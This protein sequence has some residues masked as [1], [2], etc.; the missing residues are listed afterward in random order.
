MS[1]ELTQKFEKVIVHLQSVLSELRTGR[2]SPA[3]VE[4]MP[5]ESYGSEMPLKS[6][7]SISIPEAR[8][9][10]IKPWDKNGLLAIQKA[11]QTSNIGLN[12]VV[13]QDSIR[14]TIPALTEER[15]KDLV[16]TMK[17]RLEEARIAIRKA[18]EDEM[19][20]IEQKEKGGE[21]SESEK[22]R[23]K[24]VAQK[25]VDDFN[26]K[27]DTMGQEKEKEIMTV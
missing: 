26:K 19:K 11:I 24:E 27:I 18:R 1:T 9:I 22:F 10:L 16:K 17:Q 20:S 25:I 8:Q 13:D 14:L 4:N 12:P 15:R 21:I 2:A 5:V 23:R 6:L 3:L 7:A